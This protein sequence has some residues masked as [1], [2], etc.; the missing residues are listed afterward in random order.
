MSVV[1]VFASLEGFQLQDLGFIL[2]EVFIS[3]VWTWLFLIKYITRATV[4]NYK[5]SAEVCVS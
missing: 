1:E 2:P 4:L 5:L 3:T